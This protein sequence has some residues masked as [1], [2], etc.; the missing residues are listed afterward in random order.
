V[1]GP[2]IYEF[3]VSFNSI[4]K[5]GKIKETKMVTPLFI[6]TEKHM[7]PTTS[8]YRKA[9]EVSKGDTIILSL[10]LLGI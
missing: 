6:A 7:I 9:K 3:Y 5:F 8:G 10:D 4:K 2:T 1:L